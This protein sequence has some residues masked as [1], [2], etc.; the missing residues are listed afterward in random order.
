MRQLTAQPGPYPSQLTCPCR[1]HVC[2]ASLAAS[3][4]GLLIL[5]HSVTAKW[6]PPWW[7]WHWSS[8][9]TATRSATHQSVAH[10]LYSLQRAL[11]GPIKK[12][13]A[14]A[15]AVADSDAES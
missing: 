4:Q 1:L 11:A 8:A 14:A 3:L 5:E 6:L 2:L 12:A 7:R 15:K 10:R 13:A 9:S